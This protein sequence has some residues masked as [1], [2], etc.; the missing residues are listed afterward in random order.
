MNQ[1]NDVAIAN[2]GTLYASDPNW[3]EASGKLWK[4]TLDGKM[5]LLENSMEDT[6]SKYT[7]KK[8]KIK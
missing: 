8:F 3:K 6:S 2:D 5:V 1:P 4:V 7:I